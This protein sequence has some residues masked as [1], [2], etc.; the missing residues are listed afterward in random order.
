MEGLYLSF[1]LHVSHTLIS[2]FRVRKF[3]IHN[4]I[5]LWF[6]IVVIMGIISVHY[7]IYQDVHGS[8][9][10]LSYEPYIYEFIGFLL[11]VWPFHYLDSNQVLTDMPDTN[12]TLMIILNILVVLFL[13]YF[14]L[15]IKIY[16]YISQYELV[17][18]YYSLTETGKTLY[19]YSWLEEKIAFICGDAY[20][21]FAPLVLIYAIN[22]MINS[23]KV[24]KKVLFYLIIILGCK[25]LENMSRGGRGGAFWFIVLLSFVFIPF[26]KQFPYQQ[27][28]IL[29]RFAILFFG[30]SFAYSAMMS[31]MR[32]ETS[33]IESPTSQ[34][35]RYLGEPYPHF[36][37]EFWDKVKVHPFGMR[38]FPLIT[39]TKNEN[40]SFGYVDVWATVMDVPIQNYP[41]MYGDFYC[42]F[43]KVGGLIAIFILSFIFYL[44]VKKKPYTFSKYPIIYLYL[45]IAVTGPYWFSQRGNVG[46]RALIATVIMF[47]IIEALVN[48]KNNY[49]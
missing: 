28:R 44:F 29:T 49:N 19:N 26:F 15:N 8:I 47:F 14:L 48:R 32:A 30:I 24:N 27:K 21:W 38:M 2:F 42:E 35:I 33:D 1:F 22:I 7:N 31:V 3:T 5:S 13:L 43:G 20:R 4:I 12:R 6:T 25:F 36:G 40:E 41:T 17:D 34:V 39:G 45:Q 10:H 16:Y 37:N 18:S 46:I 11:F 23:T 9:N